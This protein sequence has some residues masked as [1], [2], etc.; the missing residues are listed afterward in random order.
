M[1]AVVFLALLGVAVVSASLY[2]EHEY[3]FLFSKWIAQ[4][5]KKYNHEN[6]F[7]R[8]TV[9]KHN[10]DFITRE[11][12]KGHK[13][14]LGMN[15]FGDLSHEEFKA[16]YASGYRSIKDTVHRAR[17]APAKK[18]HKDPPASFDWTT[19]GAVT[20]VKNQQQCG[21]CWAFSATGSMEGAYFIAKKTLP[22]LSEQQL[23]D[24]STAQGNQGCNGGLMDNAF[25]YVI[26][27]GGITSEAAYPYKAVNGPCQ[28][29][30]SVA[31]ISS[32]QDVAQGDEKALQTAVLLGPVS[33][34][35]EADQQCFQFYTS[36]VLTDPSC[37][38]QLDHGV[39][40]VGYGT[41]ATAGD[42]WK[43]KNSW[44]TGWGMDGYI[45]IARG[46]NECGIAQEPSYPIV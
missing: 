14:T 40:A 22:S 5:N 46:T 18:T 31:T 35:I 44:G 25:Q 10:M 32:F 41:D 36:G 3:Q 38:T 12:K 34:A 8:Y 2:S 4:H 26:Q 13:Y 16:T 33:V 27:N 23:V 29:A 15:A 28:T 6:F 19:Q 9:F 17:N 7:Y 1:K 37:G 43:V 11:N 30:K 42:F 24:C 39:L 45:L 20:P 21:S